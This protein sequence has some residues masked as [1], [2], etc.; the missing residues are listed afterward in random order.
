VRG[1]RRGEAARGG[2]RGGAGM[3][4][5]ELEA[6]EFAPAIDDALVTAI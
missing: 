1:V 3:V 5:E 2:G 6:E 4:D